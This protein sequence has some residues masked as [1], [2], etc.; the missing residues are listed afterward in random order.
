VS[1]ERVFELAPHLTERDREIALALYDQQL[2]HVEPDA[3]AGR[4]VAPRPSRVAE[5]AVPVEKLEADQTRAFF[6]SGG[7]RVWSAQT[8]RMRA[9]RG[10][11]ENLVD[12]AI[13]GGRVAWVCEEQ[14]LSSCAAT[15]KTATLAQSRPVDVVKLKYCELS[16]AARGSL[17]VYS[18][19]RKLWRLEGS[20]KRLVRIEPMVS[21]P[22]SVD[23]DRVLLERRSGSLEV[24]TAAGALIRV[25]RFASR[26]A[27]AELAGD[28]VVVLKREEDSARLLVIRLRD[29][30]LIRSW[31]LPAADTLEFESAY[32][33]LAV[34]VVGIAL[35]VM[36]L[37]DGRDVALMFPQQVGETHARLVAGGLFYS[38][39]RAYAARTGQLG[40]I[41]RSRLVEL[42]AVKAREWRQPLH[43]PR[44][45]ATGP[46]S[47]AGQRGGFA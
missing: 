7:L 37:E 42:D 4:A 33:K 24:V 17:V 36:N 9:Q 28:R 20:R 30:K 27:D 23:G 35:H 12:L 46:L 44:L 45:S 22:L 25:L 26:P 5:L 2:G 16:V 29:G 21:R 38:H 31:P 6:S 43:I 40:F 15:L 47:D 1:A 8:G 11:C 34:Y 32:G 39:G 19:G 3:D 13:A 10:D 14:F 41:P 18:T